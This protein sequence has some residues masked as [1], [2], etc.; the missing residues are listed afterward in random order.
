MEENKSVDQKSPIDAL[1]ESFSESG[2]VDDDRLSKQLAVVVVG[3]G[4]LPASFSRALARH[5]KILVIDGMD[6][7]DMALT[8]S[9][10]SEAIRPPM[11]YTAGCSITSGKGKKSR[12]NREKRWH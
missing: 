1:D 3:G 9:A 2:H 10:L 12:W 8:L 4:S 11:C 7:P 6:R 5:G